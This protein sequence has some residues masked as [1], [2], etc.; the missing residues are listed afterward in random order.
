M[1]TFLGS[2]VRLLVSEAP[3]LEGIRKRGGGVLCPVFWVGL[4]HPLRKWFVGKLFLLSSILGCGF[5]S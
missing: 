4:L 3:T 5:W 1:L 2:K